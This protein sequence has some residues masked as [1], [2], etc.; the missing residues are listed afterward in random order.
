MLPYLLLVRKRI[1]KLLIAGSLALTLSMSTTDAAST[2]E[3]DFSILK[4]TEDY[5]PSFT[6]EE[7]IAY[8]QAKKLI[9]DGE[10]EVRSGEYLVNRKPSALNPNEDL[11]PLKARGKQLVDAGN[12][13]IH[14]GRV[15]IVELLESAKVRVDALTAKAANR[16]YQLES[17]PYADALSHGIDT[18][19][20]TCWEKEYSNILYDKVYIS[21]QATTTAADPQ[22]TNDVYDI[23]VEKDGR[24]FTVNLAQDLGFNIDDET[25]EAGLSYGNASIHDAA[26]S[27]LLIIELLPVTTDNQSGLLNLKVIDW[28]SRVIIASSLVNVSGLEL[29]ESEI[30]DFEANNSTETIL[31]TLVLSDPKTVFRIFEN[32]EQPYQFECSVKGTGVSRASLTIIKESLIQTTKLEFVA[33]SL[34]RRLYVAD[35]DADRFQRLASASINISAENENSYSLSAMDKESGR[36]LEIGSVTF[37]E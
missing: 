37:S 31:S 14:Q 6:P 16:S 34:L 24:K 2:P 36:T 33:D 15:K 8:V 13:K 18:L 21:S 22:R 30:S 19:L 35:A 26:K 27:A 10:S 9:N 29:T 1:A 23:L 32:L 12:A 5:L 3:V 7:R 11:G 17:K 4:H 25:G 20:D 28:Q